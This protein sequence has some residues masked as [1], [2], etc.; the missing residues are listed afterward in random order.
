MSGVGKAKQE[1]LHQALKEVEE[2]VSKPGSEQLLLDLKAALPRHS[3]GG[4]VLPEVLSTQ[5]FGVWELGQFVCVCASACEC[6]TVW[7]VVWLPWSLCARAQ[8]MDVHL[9]L[10][11][12]ANE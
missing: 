3:S 8:C 6:M 1:K 2:A 9:Q 12:R 4:F 11:V 10:T 5:V 7:V